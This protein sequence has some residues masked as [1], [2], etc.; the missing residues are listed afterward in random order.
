MF[1]ILSAPTLTRVIII[2]ICSILALASFVHA[3]TM[4]ELKQCVLTSSGGFLILLCRTFEET[5]LIHIYNPEFQES[6]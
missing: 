2:T 4:P 3:M 1:H 5:H 6:W